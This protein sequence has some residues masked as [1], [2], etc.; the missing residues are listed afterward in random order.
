MDDLPLRP[1]LELAELVQRRQ[2]S[3]LELLDLHLARYEAHNPAVNAVVFTQIEQARSNARWS[4]NVLAA[5]RT[6]GPLHGVP[7]TIKDSY[8]W[9]GSP[10]TWGIPERVDN[11]PRGNAT[12]V[13]RLLDAGAIIYGKTNVPHKL[14]DWQSFNSIYGTTNN[15]WDLT[16]TPGGSSGGSAAALATGMAS[17]E[18]GSDIGASIRNPAHYCGVFGHKPTM[19]IVP[20]RGHLLPDDHAHVDILVGGPLARSAGDLKI[21]L[22]ILAGPTGAEQKA[23]RLHLPPA[24]KTDLGA[25][26][27]GMLM[28][29]PVC[30]QD[31]ELT[32]QLLATVDALERAGLQVDRNAA[33]Q[34]DWARYQE[35][36]FLL[37][38]AASGTG[39][40]DE[41]YLFHLQ[42]SESR[43]P[44]DTRY[45][46]Y[47]DR[48]VTLRYRDW[49]A[50]HNERE[51][52]R[53]LWAKFFTKYDV[54]LS[55]IAASAAFVH[56]QDGERPD[57]TILV[58]G[59]EELVVDQLFWAGLSSV[60]HLP[61]TVAPAGLTRSGLP[62]GMQIIAD[63]LED[64]T[65]LE[66]AR[67]M[68]EALGGF[69]VPPG[70]G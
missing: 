57:R 62:C 17:L 5:G 54:L 11:Y 63:Y 24:R 69:K 14:A 7:M 50:L 10:S 21:L 47:L 46:A 56:N 13:Q 51:Q 70:Y 33:P 37:L 8:D 28:D 1:A 55:P 53:K 65:A 32:E 59:R 3:A 45:R 26:R 19:G 18:I 41:E 68:E 58:N 38:R 2:I 35:V 61:S 60:V 43:T 40:S 9:V 39:F 4:D 34:F 64:N 23:W 22:E 44:K 36:Y 29:S 52:M 16:R 66:F 6:L 30:A 48:G 42:S 20:L 31:D 15:P 25:F 12:A 49:F 27:V 67:L